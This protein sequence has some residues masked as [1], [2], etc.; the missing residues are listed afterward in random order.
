[1][2]TGTLEPPPRRWFT[3]SFPDGFGCSR[4]RRLGRS[5]RGPYVCGSF[6]LRGLKVGGIVRNAEGQ[7]IELT[8]KAKPQCAVVNAK[9]SS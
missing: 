8:G 1:M 2:L 4:L 7:W 9:Q 3:R 6:F 5:F